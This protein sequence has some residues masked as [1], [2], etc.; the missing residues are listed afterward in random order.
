MNETYALP[1]FEAL[2]DFVRSNLCER[3]ALDPATTP[4]VRTPLIRRGELWGYA[5]QVEG[6]RQLRTSAIWS[7][8]DDRILF[9]NSIGERVRD[10]TLSDSPPL[11]QPLAKAA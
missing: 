1:S 10:V 3:D 6:P 8:A 2:C 7:A 5:F 9:Y 4:F 11:H